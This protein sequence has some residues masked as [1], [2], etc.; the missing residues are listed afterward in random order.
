M[1]RRK[2][3]EIF[4]LSFLDVLSGALGA[5]IFLFIVVPKGDGEAPAAEP[6]LSVM[7]DT[8]QGQFFGEIPDSLMGKEIGDSLLAVVFEYKRLPSIKDCP[9]QRKCP[10][11]P[12][13][14]PQ[15]KPEKL[16]ASKKEEAVAKKEPVSTPK[17]SR[18]SGTLPSVPCNYSS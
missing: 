2:E 3:L 1:K 18:Y 17:P 6:Q 5:V 9:P 14:P 8:V 15:R 10:E 4:N 16:S 7:F 12:P 11:C 13:C